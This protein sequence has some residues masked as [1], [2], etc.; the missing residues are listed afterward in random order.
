M[1]KPQYATRKKRKEEPIY[2]LGILLRYIQSKFGYIEQFGEQKHGDCAISS[3][4]AFT[5]LRLTEIYRAKAT[6]N[7][8]GSRQLD[9]AVW[10]RDDYNLT[11]PFRPVS[12]KQICPTK[13]RESRQKIVSYEYLSKAVHM[14]MKGADDQAKNSVTSIRKSSSTKSIDQG[15]SQQEVDRASRHKEGAGTVAV[16]YDVYFNDRLREGLTNFE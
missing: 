11:V 7:E 12:L 4:M 2:K 14:I 15:A 13:W 8:N 10:K 6:G 5:T 16:S 9:I 3:I 1:K